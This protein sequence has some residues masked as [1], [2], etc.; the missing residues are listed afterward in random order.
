MVLAPHV[1]PELEAYISKWRAELKPT[2]NMLF[3]R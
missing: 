3:S 2:H 1:Y